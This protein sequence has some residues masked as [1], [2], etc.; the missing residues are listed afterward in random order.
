[1][2]VPEFFPLGKGKAQPL[3][4]CMARVFQGSATM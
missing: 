4:A 2:S 3:V 1:V